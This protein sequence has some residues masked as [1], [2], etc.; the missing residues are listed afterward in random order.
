MEGHQCSI[1]LT[2]EAW[3]RSWLGFWL[4]GWR[5][6]L[7]GWLL[8]GWTG[9]PGAESIRQLEG[10]MLIPGWLQQPNWK[11]TRLERRKITRMQDW[12]T[13]RASRLSTCKTGRLER[14][15]GCQLGK[16]SSTAWW[17]LKG[18]ADFLFV[19]VFLSTSGPTPLADDKKPSFC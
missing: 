4:A 10:K 8:A 1:W 11:L 17:P 5:L 15:Q 3:R 7:A 2:L 19:Y 6:L 9:T 14:L 18:P 12:R 16:K 13:G